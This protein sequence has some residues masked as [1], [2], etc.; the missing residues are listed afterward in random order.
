MTSKRRKEGKKMKTYEIK[1]GK[2]MKLAQ[3]Y[4]IDKDGG[5]YAIITRREDKKYFVAIGCDVNSENYAEWKVCDTHKEAKNYLLGKC[6]L[7][8]PCGLTLVDESLVES[9]TSEE[10][11]EEAK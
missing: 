7:A 4:T 8:L 11:K 5:I 1:E 9:I 3:R 6:R 2:T 10:N